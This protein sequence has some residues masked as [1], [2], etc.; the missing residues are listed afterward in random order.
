[1]QGSKILKNMKLV[2]KLKTCSKQFKM[3][4]QSVGGWY[5]SFSKWQKRSCVFICLMKSSFAKM[6]DYQMMN[7][8]ACL[9]FGTTFNL[10]LSL[11][12]AK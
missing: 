10:K 3:P 9:C 6:P 7:I 5:F 1:M 2:I 8:F 4:L 12:F 11:V